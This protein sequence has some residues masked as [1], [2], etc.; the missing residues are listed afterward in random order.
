MQRYLSYFFVIVLVICSFSNFNATAGVEKPVAIGLLVPITGSGAVLS[1][2]LIAAA[3]IAVDEANE[4]CKYSGRS[5][6][7]I[8]EDTQTRPAPGME[9]ARKLIEIDKVP[10]ITGGYSS[11]VSL[12]IAKYAQER[13]IVYLVAIP[14]SPL[15]SDVGDYIFSVTIPDTFKGKAMAEF[16]I[17]DSGKKKYGLMFQNNAFGKG[18]MIETKKSLLK[19][20]AEIVAEVPYELDRAD[21]KAELQRLFANKPEAIIANF[22]PKE[23]FISFKQAY[24]LGYL[25]INKIPW[26]D[27]EIVSS[28]TKALEEI[29]DALEG[30]KGIEPLVPEQFFTE[31]FKQKM[32]REPQISEVAQNYDAVR[33]ITMAIMFA[34]STDPKSIANALYHVGDWYRGASYGGDKRFDKDGMQG[35]AQFRKVIIKNGKRVEYIGR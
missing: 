28:T 30:I 4:A 21:Y 18:L 22:Y 6:K 3:Q 16:A 14:T 8:V 20:G 1:E 33:M 24:E 27:P 13:G 10:V 9:A 7:L 15:F 2:D 11:G 19:L 31:R 17:K 23:G 12:P 26:Y 29:P 25:N 5:F 35:H 34:N 32:K